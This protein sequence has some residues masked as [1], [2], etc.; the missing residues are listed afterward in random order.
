MK[1]LRATPRC[2]RVPDPKPQ[3]LSPKNFSFAGCSLFR[4]R[5]NRESVSVHTRGKCPEASGDPVPGTAGACESL[6]DYNL[7]AGGLV[8]SGPVARA[9]RLFSPLVRHLSLLPSEFLSFHACSF[10]WPFGCSFCKPLAKVREKLP[11]VAEFGALRLHIIPKTGL[12]WGQ[13]GLL[14]C[15][16]QASELDFVSRSGAPGN[17][18][19]RLHCQRAHGARSRREPAPHTVQLCFR[20]HSGNQSFAHSLRHWILYSSG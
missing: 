11:I 20:R 17:T 2:P 10:C 12:L 5:F 15:T 16:L 13:K 1:H 6:E 18:R 7:S 3:I 4:S 14:A 9:A 19:G 8:L